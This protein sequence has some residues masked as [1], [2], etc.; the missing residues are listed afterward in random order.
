[1]MEIVFL[2]IRTVIKQIYLKYFYTHM[3]QNNV[4]TKTMIFIL[5]DTYDE[6]PVVLWF[7]EVFLRVGLVLLYMVENPK[8][9]TSQSQRLTYPQKPKNECVIWSMMLQTEREP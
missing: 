3:V 5:V 9:I 4:W 7:L 6:L 8:E 2:Q 1:M